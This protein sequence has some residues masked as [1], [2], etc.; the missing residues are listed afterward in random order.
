MSPS[1]P[2]ASLSVTAGRPSVRAEFEPERNF[3]RLLRQHAVL[4]SIPDALSR[5][6]PSPAVRGSGRAAQS[7]REP[8][9]PQRMSSAQA[10]PLP[11]KGARFERDKDG[12]ATRARAGALRAMLRHEAARPGAV[13]PG[14]NSPDGATTIEPTEGLGQVRPSPRAGRA[15]ATAPYGPRRSRSSAWSSG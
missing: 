11:S 5:S 12:G 9:G 7:P 13:Q 10:S 4:H 8:A 3:A 14:K 2:T 15:E 6:S 1:A